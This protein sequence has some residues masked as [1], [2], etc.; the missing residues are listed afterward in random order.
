MDKIN[1]LTQEQAYKD[2]EAAFGMVPNVLKTYGNFPGFIQPI[3]HAVVYALNNE[4]N[5]L[6]VAQREWIAFQVSTYNDCTYCKT[7]HG[8][9][10]KK[11]VANSKELSDDEKKFL[12]EFAKVSAGQPSQASSFRQKFLDRG[13]TLEQFK[14]A[15]IAA[16]LFALFN[17]LADTLNVDL[18]EIFNK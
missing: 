4:S 15:N 9:G 7:H 1:S 10:Y 11:A 16:A 8:A 14:A 5:P 2:I 12:S 6:S 18:E 17:R 3:T 13:Y